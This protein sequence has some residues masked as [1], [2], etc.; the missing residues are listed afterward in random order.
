MTFN[1]ASKKFLN[2]LVKRKA[3]A[4]I[5]I[6]LAI[7]PFTGTAFYTTYNM[8]DLLKAATIYEVAAC[9]VTMAIIAGGCDLSIGHNMTLAG[10]VTILLMPYLPLY[11]CV[12]IALAVGVLIGFINGY[13]CVYWK[14]E[15]FIITLGM[16]MLLRGVCQQLTNASPITGTVKEFMQ[17]GNAKVFGFI[18]SIALVMVAVI[19]LAYV[20][21]RYTPFGRNLYAIGGDY[22]V[23]VYSGIKVV[24]TKWIAFVI[25]GFAAAL[26]GVLLS[27]RMNSGSSLYGETTALTVNCGAVIGGTSFSGGQGGILETVLGIFVFTL[28]ENCMNMI[29]INAYIQQLIKGLIIVSIIAIDCYEQKVKAETV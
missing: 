24:R 4:F 3:L 8:M 14:T 21:M 18:P 7:M 26:S 11:A 5:I 29:G 28:L 12:L 9:G 2:V 23:A 13:L 16:G 22:E 25:S 17:F 27:A 10:I 19:I 20:I 15:P 6:L 1:N